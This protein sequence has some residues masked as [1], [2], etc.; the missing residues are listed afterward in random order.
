MVVVVVVLTG[1][2]GAASATG[3]GAVVVVVVLVD[4]VAGVVELVVVVEVTA[5]D[6]GVVDVPWT[7]A[8]SEAVDEC[9]CG[10]DELPRLT[11]TTRSAQLARRSI[12]SSPTARAWRA[13]GEG[14]GGVLLGQGAFGG[15]LTPTHFGFR[16]S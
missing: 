4:V 6:V 12:G 15:T 13:G 11:G 10:A 3:A 14:M 7:R 9:D 8:G 2:G 16:H 5:C 1:G